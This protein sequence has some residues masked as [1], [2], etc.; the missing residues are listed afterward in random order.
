MTL[1][2]TSI[3]V[4]HFRERDAKLVQLL[5]DGEAGVHPFVVGELA[6]GNLKNRDATLDNLIRLPHARVASETEVRLLLDASRLWGNGLGWVDVHLLAAAKLSG[7]ALFTA[8]RALRRAGSAIG[9][10]IV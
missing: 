4:N 8:D 2:D 3:W 10:V 5:I 1:I 6:C 9:A 7:W